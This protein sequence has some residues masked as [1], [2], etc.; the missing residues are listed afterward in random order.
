MFR[1][2]AEYKIPVSST[3]NRKALDLPTDSDL[4]ERGDMQY[5]CRGKSVE[6]VVC[7][8]DATV[9]AVTT[10]D[11]TTRKRPDGNFSVADGAIEMFKPKAG[12][13]HVSVI[14]EDG[15]STGF[16]VIT[17]GVGE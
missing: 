4:V 10:V 1:A 6:S 5:R 14:A 9:A 2:I 15:A 8:G 13:T 7:F 3:Q 16:V 17:I 12:Q 11:A